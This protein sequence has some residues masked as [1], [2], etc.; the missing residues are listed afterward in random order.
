MFKSIPF[1]LFAQL[2]F[3]STDSARKGAIILKAILEAQSPRLSEIAQKMPGTPTAN[4]KCLQRFLASTDPQTTLL[5]L[6]QTEAPFVLGDPTEMPRPQARKTAYVGTLMD[7]KTKGFWLLTLATPFRGR[8]LP[9]HF[10]T[11]S[12]KT[13]ADE[14]S[15]RNLKHFRALAAV[16]ELLGEKPLVFDRE[17]SY[18]ELLENLR[19]EQVHFVIRLNLRSHPPELINAKRQSVVLTIAPEETEIYP[20]LYY[21]GRVPISVIGVWKKGL[22]EPLWVMT[23]LKAEVGLDIYFQRMKIDESFRD[24]KNLLHLDK[25]MNK[26][27]E[28]MEKM[29]ALV[30]LAYSIGV[31][32]GEGIRDAVYA[33]RI[34][35]RAKVLPLERIPDQPHLR[36]GKKWKLYSG[37]FI[38]LKQNLGI[39]RKRRRKICHQ[40]LPIFTG[41]VR[42]PVRTHV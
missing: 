30:M 22:S 13:I 2:L 24:L 1:F 23:D 36:Q 20:Q 32:T 19:A 7:G 11:Y 17:F 40:V 9:F 42:H 15:S 8:A 21:K 28:Q 5:R 18:L 39:S 34:P 10:V 29:I 25:V 38:L 41:L 4:Y 26:K 31:L 35:D 12:S 14:E 37:L 3:D 6:F 33:E 16:K 27:P